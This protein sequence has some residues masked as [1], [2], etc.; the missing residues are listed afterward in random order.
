ML[1]RRVRPVVLLMRTTR[2]TE[3]RIARACDEWVAAVARARGCTEEH[4]ARYVLAE[5]E[6]ATAQ[7]RELEA[8]HQE[9]AE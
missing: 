1:V 9:A 4:A 3:A 6:R 5:I 7:A 2:I 8:A